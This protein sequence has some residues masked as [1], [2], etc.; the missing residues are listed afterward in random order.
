MYHGSEANSTPPGPEWLAFEVE[1][2]E[3]FALS[4]ALRGKEQGQAS[5]S[6]VLQKPIGPMC[7]L[8]Q[9]APNLPRHLHP[10]SPN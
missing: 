1:H 3:A 5:L 8:Q 6:D 4:L 10:Y 2:A 9:S 7:A